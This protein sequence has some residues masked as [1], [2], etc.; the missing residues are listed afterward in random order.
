MDASQ[1]VRIVL[2][3]LRGR[4]GIGNEL[5]EIDPDIYEEMVGDLEV[6]VQEAIDG[7]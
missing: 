3:D 6:K 7:S 4:K 5:E 2:D 1:I